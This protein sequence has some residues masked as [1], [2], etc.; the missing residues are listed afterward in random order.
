MTWEC[1]YRLEPLYLACRPSYII[2]AQSIFG[3]SRSNFSTSSPISAEIWQ[4]PRDEAGLQLGCL[5]SNQK[6]SATKGAGQKVLTATKLHSFAAAVGLIVLWRSSAGVNESFSFG[7]LSTARPAYHRPSDQVWESCDTWNRRQARMLR[8]T[9]SAV[10]ASQP[11]LLE[12]FIFQL[13][14][15]KRSC[16]LVLFVDPSKQSSKL[17]IRNQPAKRQSL[18]TQ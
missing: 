7:V 3:D 16:G 15:N 18:R 6:G 17:C 8:P 14:Q 13:Q 2:S 10:S 12:R 11:V 9:M 1:R 5:N 4:C